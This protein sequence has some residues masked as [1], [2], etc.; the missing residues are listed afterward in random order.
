[1]S[2]TFEVQV[3]VTYNWGEQPIISVFEG[4]LNLEKVT[5]KRNEYAA[6]AFIPIDLVIEAV[7]V[8]ALEKFILEPLL[9]P[10]AEK[11]DWRRAVSK[12]LNPLQPFNLVIRVTPANLIIE[13]PLETRHQIT[14]EIWKIIQKSLDIIKTEHINVTRIRFTP[15]KD[16]N[17]LILCYEKSLPTYVINLEEERIE[18]LSSSQ[19]SQLEEVNQSAE[20]WVAKVMNRAKA[21]Q[22]Y[23]KLL[24]K[25]ASNLPDVEE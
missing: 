5:L 23:V 15:D 3:Q 18:Q 14:A 19:V 21:Y 25:Q 12:F 22:E 1:M 2:K 11:L 10:I 8:Y 17:L 16:G 24:L 7:S 20:E 9:S 6:K 4:N 13:A